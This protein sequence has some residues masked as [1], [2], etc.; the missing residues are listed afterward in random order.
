M[1]RMLFNCYPLWMG[2]LMHS[3]P[4]IRPS[5]EPTDRPFVPLMNDGLIGVHCP[6]DMTTFLLY[7]IHPL[8]GLSLSSK[9]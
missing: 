6:H 2:E 8:I 9:L 1:S 4:T 5:R 7:S 3:Y